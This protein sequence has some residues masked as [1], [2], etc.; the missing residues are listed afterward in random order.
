MSTGLVQAQIEHSECFIS[1]HRSEGYGL[2]IA[3]ALAA[4]RPTIATGY[5]GNM[6]F[7]SSDY[8]YLVPYDL[9]EVGDNA[10]P[11][12]PTAQWAQPNLAA[13]SQH[14]RAIFDNYSLALQHADQEKGLIIAHQSI[15]NAIKSIQPLIMN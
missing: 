13:A 11:Y 6:T 3:A 5:S 12:E 9:V 10:Q 1:L 7:T 15:E 14:M 2:N 4:G 8:P